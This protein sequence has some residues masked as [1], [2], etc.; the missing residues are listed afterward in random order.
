MTDKRFSHSNIQQTSYHLSLNWQRLLSLTENQFSLLLW[1]FFHQSLKD[2]KSPQVFRTLLSILAD[3]RNAVVLMVF[4]CPLICL[5]VSLPILWRLFRV[6]ELQLV[7][8][9]PSC[10]IVAGGVGGVFFIFCCLFVCLFVFCFLLFCCFFFF[11]LA[12]GSCKVNVLIAIFAFVLFY[13]VI[14]RDGKIHYSAGSLFSFLS[15]FFFFFLLT[16]T[17]FAICLHL[18]IHENV[19]RLIPHYRFWFVQNFFFC[20]LSLGL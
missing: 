1:E 14:S 17:R 2:S 18:K 12:G 20:W 7:S 6:H 4:T 15:S 5:P 3:L 11:F 10:S 9:S 16:L 13:F 19:K 8:P